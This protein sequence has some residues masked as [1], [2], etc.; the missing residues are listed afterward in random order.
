[1]VASGIWFSWF[2][3]LHG[4]SACFLL[5]ERLA[6]PVNHILQQMSSS[7]EM[8][9]HVGYYVPITFIKVHWQSLNHSTFQKLF[10]IQQCTMYELSYVSY[11]TRP[12]YWFAMCWA[13]WFH[14][15]LVVTL[16]G[17]FRAEP[18][19]LNGKRVRVFLW[20]FL[21]LVTSAQLDLDKRGQQK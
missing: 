1:M 20:K 7:V 11:T 5:L 17:G 10:L 19:G 8:H 2:G 15:C 4:R 14:C 21:A 16:D 3:S 13:V 12:C 18:C 6:F 9:V